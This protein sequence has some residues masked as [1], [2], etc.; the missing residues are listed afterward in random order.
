M[1]QH[2]GLSDVEPSTS[3]EIESYSISRPPNAR[4]GA[5]R[6]NFR[7]FRPRSC[8]PSLKL[9]PMSRRTSFSGLDRPAYLQEPVRDDYT[10]C[11]PVCAHTVSHLDGR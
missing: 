3:D 7:A 5:M 4:P 1:F 2:P 9:G 11:D 6:L 8:A 10:A